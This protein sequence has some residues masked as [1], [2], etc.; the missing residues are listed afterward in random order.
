MNKISRLQG[1][2]HLKAVRK[3]RVMITW[4]S[5]LPNIKKEFK[6]TE[7]AEKELLNN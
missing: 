4:L 7:N 2:L 5:T 1:L 6:I 3:E